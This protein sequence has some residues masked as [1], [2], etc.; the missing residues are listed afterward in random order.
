MRPK[1]ID[2]DIAHLDRLSSFSLS[3]VGTTDRASARDKSSAAAV[4]RQ[5]RT[6]HQIPD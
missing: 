1:K 2:C 6:A 4:V 3:M 5:L